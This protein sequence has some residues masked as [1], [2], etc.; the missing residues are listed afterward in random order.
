MDVGASL[1]RRA[2]VAAAALNLD[3]KARRGALLS[4][5]SI[6]SRAELS[7]LA[8]SLLWSLPRNG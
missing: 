2:E 3:P 5:T 6:M 1:V 8:L 4:C 7:E